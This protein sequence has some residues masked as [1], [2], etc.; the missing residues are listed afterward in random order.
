MHGLEGIRGV[1]LDVDG[2]LL[3]HDRAVE[4]VA[5]MLPR[6]RASGLGLRVTT[7]ITRRPRSGIVAMLDAAG[8]RIAVGEILAP[9]WLARGLILESGKPRAALFVPR[10]TLADFEGVEPDE[11]AP[12]W[13][14]VGD[15]GRDWSWDR[16][17]GAFRFLRAGARL[18]ALHRNRFWLPGPEGAVLDA[19]PFVAALEY[20]AGV[21][22][23]I[24]GKPSPAFFHLAVSSLG[25]LPHQ[26]LVVGDDPETDGAGARAAGCRTAL[27]RTGKYGEREPTQPGFEPDIVLDTA[28]DL[29]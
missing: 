28:A 16:L 5:A 22:A 18:L 15:L 27:V 14:V 4:G 19:G 10:E 25:L 11:V 7:N 6:L 23:E 26:V 9:P 21:E 3:V 12:D 13:V 2:T 29:L 24:V 1:L 17:N 20:A 8:L